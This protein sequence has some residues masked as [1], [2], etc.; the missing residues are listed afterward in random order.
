MPTFS[1]LLLL[2]LLG[3]GVY[4]LLLVLLQQQ[5]IFPGRH[6]VP[7]QSASG[8]AKGAEKLWLTTS[9]GA[10]E[11]RFIVPRR[12]GRQP[13]VLFFHGNAELID[14]LS[15]DLEQLRRIGWGVLLVEYPGYGRSAGSPSQS[16]LTETALAAYDQLLL[17]PEV[18]P[19]RIIAF[20]FSLG[21]G[22][23]VALSTQR[24][25]RALI[26]AA[27]LASLRPFARE[28]LVPPFLL[29]D[30]FDSVA[31]IGQYDGPT[32]VLHGRNDS[33]MPFS[34]GKQLAAAAPRGRLVVLTADHH[35]LL[36]STAFWQA[37]SSFTHGEQ[38]VD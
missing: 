25:V 6:L 16:T 13:L 31:Q 34:H 14:G 30:T 20:G 32:L 18:D 1:R 19:S 10:V 11:A 9:F 3:Y 26:L 22:P 15:P 24:P 8:I 33:V 27:P 29:R 2:C 12:A 4:A 38:L 5:L 21:A 28:R 17:R 36:G 35:D 7:V 23:A 37:V